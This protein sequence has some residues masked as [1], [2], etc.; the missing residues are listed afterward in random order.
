MPLTVSRHSHSF[1]KGIKHVIHT[2][3]I[4]LSFPQKNWMVP[5]F[6]GH[7]LAGNDEVRDH[8]LHAPGLFMQGAVPPLSLRPT[9][10]EQTTRCPC[11]NWAHVHRSLS[12]DGELCACACQHVQE[13][14]PP[15]G[16]KR[17]GTSETL[18]WVP[19]FLGVAI[20]GEPT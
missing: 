20:H 19:L 12:S 16:R 4:G 17:T 18:S 13:A 10:K 2:L 6:Q 5:K 14:I 11:T 3:K 15:L 7:D 9:L 1:L 8:L